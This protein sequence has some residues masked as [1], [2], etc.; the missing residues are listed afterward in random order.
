MCKAVD[1]NIKNKYFLCRTWL[2]WYLSEVWT[3]ARF[4]LPNLGQ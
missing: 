3:F 2:G 1:K 4:Q